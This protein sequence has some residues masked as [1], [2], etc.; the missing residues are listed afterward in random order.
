[1]GNRQSQDGSNSKS[2]CE[3][4]F[5]SLCSNFQTNQHAH[6][7][8]YAVPAS[9][10]P[11]TSLP[12]HDH[13]SFSN[14]IQIKLTN[15][16]G[17][18]AASTGLARMSKADMRMEDNDAFSDYINR[19]KFKIKAMSSNVSIERVASIADDAYETR[20]EDDEGDMFMDFIKRTKFKI[21]KTS[22]IGSRMN[23]SFKK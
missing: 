8:Q 2:V 15:S 13:T 1:M 20:Q 23:I 11:N 19:T 4:I 18:E 16:S 17:A 9:S 14:S 3:K 22:S 5:S 7:K 12:T 21:R 10:A 6:H